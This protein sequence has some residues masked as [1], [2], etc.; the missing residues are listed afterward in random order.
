M[1]PSEANRVE[2]N[3]H[4]KK[5]V[6]GGGGGGPTTSPNLQWQSVIQ[7][8]KPL[9]KESGF[10]VVKSYINIYLVITQATLILGVEINKASKHFLHLHVRYTYT[11][12]W[13][14]KNG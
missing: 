1:D 13:M 6:E 4:R 9:N 7:I 2:L 12:T 3:S 11:D 8:I 10:W 5:E 14:N